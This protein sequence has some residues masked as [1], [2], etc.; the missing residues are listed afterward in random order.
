MLIEEGSRIYSYTRFKLQLEQS[1]ECKICTQITLN[2]WYSVADNIDL[3]SIERQIDD[4][5]AYI[6][7]Q[8]NSGLLGR[9]L[10]AWH[11]NIE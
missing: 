4:A 2:N 3:S 10:A 8:A 1:L 5:I 9:V 6:H 11:D 7:D